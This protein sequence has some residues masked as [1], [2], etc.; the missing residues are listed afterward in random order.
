M[1]GRKRQKK[2]PER[3]DPDLSESRKL[4]EDYPVVK[5]GSMGFPKDWEQHPLWADKK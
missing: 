3:G 1:L 4:L 5:L 2:P